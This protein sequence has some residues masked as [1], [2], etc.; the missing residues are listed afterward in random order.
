MIIMNYTPRGD[1]QMNHAHWCNIHKYVGLIH[2]CGM[3]IEDVYGF[4]IQ[5]N[6]FF[7]KLYMISFVSI[8]F[9]WILC[10]DECVIS[11]VMKKLENEQYILGNEP[12]NVNDI[13]NL[14][15]NEKQYLIFY[16][17]NNLLRV[18]SVVVVN[19]RTTHINHIILVPTFVLYLCYTY[20]I[21]YKLHYN[22]KFYPYFQICFCMYLFSVLYTTVGV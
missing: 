7:D 1:S 15:V 5:K 11:Y 12:D 19:N 21:T 13:R 17:I 4:I 8:P 20:D 10:K 16:H 18:F 3:I 6:V 14:F 9:S 2:L 22:K